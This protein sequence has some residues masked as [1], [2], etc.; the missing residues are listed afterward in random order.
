MAPGKAPRVYM[1]DGM[2]KTPVA[3]MTI[4]YIVS[5]WPCCGGVIVVLTFQE[6]Y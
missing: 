6:N 2:V 1:A 3:K 5:P 4:C